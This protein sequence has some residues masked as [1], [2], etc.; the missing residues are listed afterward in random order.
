[1]NNSNPRVV[2]YSDD[3]ELINALVGKA[4]SAQTEAASH[5]EP[6][7]KFYSSAID[8]R[9]IDADLREADVAIYDLD[10]VERHLGQVAQDILLIKLNAGDTPLFLTG[11]RDSLDAALA[12]REIAPLIKRTVAKPLIESHLQVLVRAVMSNKPDEGTKSVPARTSNFLAFGSV[13]VTAL[14]GS[15]MYMSL[16]GANS[17]LPVGGPE[18]QTVVSDVDNATQVMVDQL[19]AKSTGSGT[20]SLMRKAYASVADNKFVAPHLNNALHFADRVLER[21]PYHNEAY[22]F[23]QRLLVDA[24]ASV[25]ILISDGD[26]K[27][28]AERIQLLKQAE[29][30]S[31]DNARLLLSLDKARSAR[32]SFQAAS[33]NTVKTEA[34]VASSSDDTTDSVA[35]VLSATPRLSTGQ[36]PV[37][38]VDTPTPAD[39]V[40]RVASVVEP[41]VSNNDFAVAPQNAIVASLGRSPKFSQPVAGVQAPKPEVLV[42]IKTASPRYPEIAVERDI[43]GWVDVGYQVDAQGRPV[44]VHII[45]SEPRRVFDRSALKAMKKWRFEAPSESRNGGSAMSKVNTKRFSFNLGL[46][47]G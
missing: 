22:Q 21:E 40:S 36:A 47:A 32:A 37:A 4:Y 45:K 18:A 29:P 14:F 43:E 26:Y 16:S 24:R 42:A 6:A 7:Y 34:D 15:V 46:L 17:E 19:D 28:A 9:D 31:D 39:P 10:L 1:M 30:F 41:A 25:H 20:E 33:A 13:V 8:T 11:K 23:R 5:N 27:A 3:N 35:S 44:N 38:A 12:S 2:I